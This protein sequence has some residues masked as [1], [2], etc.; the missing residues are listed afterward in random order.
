MKRRTLIK[1]GL[2][3]I[4]SLYLY[5]LFG[6]NAIAA[7]KTGLSAHFQPT[8]NSLA[9]YQVPD[10]FRDAKFGIWA[11]WA[12]NVSPNMATGTPTA[13]TRKV[14]NSIST[15]AKRMGTPQNLALKM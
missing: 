14:V 7:G 2:T 5:K 15:I 12:R 9:Q 8:W 10:W 13:C 4:P 3:V 11:H 6:R 1:G